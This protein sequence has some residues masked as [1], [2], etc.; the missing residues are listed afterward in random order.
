MVN[1]CLIL[2]CSQALPDSGLVCIWINEVIPKR[3]VY[4][5]SRC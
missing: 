1:S 5:Y 2:G 4:S 3:G